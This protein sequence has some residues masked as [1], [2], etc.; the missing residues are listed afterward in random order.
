MKTTY[1]YLLSLL[2]L[3]L[4][5]CSSSSSSEFDLE[6]AVSSFTAATSY[7]YIITV[8]RYNATLLSKIMK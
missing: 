7:R 4:T 3:P 1:T 6:T 2:V 8:E 5:A